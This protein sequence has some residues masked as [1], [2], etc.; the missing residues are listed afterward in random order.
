MTSMTADWFIELCIV[1]QF[2]GAHVR[3]ILASKI[4][5]SETSIVRD[6]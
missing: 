5:T 4:E 3:A 6:K 1:A 2:I